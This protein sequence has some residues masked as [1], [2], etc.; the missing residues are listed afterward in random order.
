MTIETRIKKLLAEQTLLPADSV[1]PG[2]ELVA[3]LGL[4]SLDMVELTMALEQDFEINI[5]DD[6]FIALKTVQQVIDHIGSLASPRP[7]A[8]GG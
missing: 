1:Q 6:E 3:H 8:G 7:L 4:D 5:D 2:D